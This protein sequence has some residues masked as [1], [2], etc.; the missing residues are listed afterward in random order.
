F[1]LRLPPGWAPGEDTLAR[2]LELAKAEGLGLVQALLEES[3]DGVVA[4]RLERT[5]FLARAA[6]VVKPGEALE[7]AVD[8]VSGVVWVDG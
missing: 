7:D 1:V 5:A 3:P 2:L 4:A 8:D 6:I